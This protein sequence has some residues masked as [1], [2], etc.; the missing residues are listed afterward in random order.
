MRAT[1]YLDYETVVEIN[2]QHCGDGG[3]IRDEGG[4]R[5]TLGRA[6]ATFMGEDLHPTIVSKA[7]VILHGLSS[8]QYFLDGN[9]RTAWIVAKLFL[10]LNGHHLRDG[11][12]VEHETLVLS[13]ATKAFENEEHPERGAAKAAEWYATRRLT[14]Q[15]RYHYAFLSEH[16]ELVNSDTFV[17]MNG[18]L[19]SYFATELPA[20]AP[21]SLAIHI[22]W[23]RWDKFQDMEVRV[24]IEGD[25]SARIVA[26]TAELAAQLKLAESAGAPIDLTIMTDPKSTLNYSSISVVPIST[27]DP[28]HPD[29]MS[30]HLLI[31][32]LPVWLTDPGT[33]WFRV[34]VN[35]ELLTRLGLDVALDTGFFHQQ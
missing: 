15:D 32:N 13:V 4:I 12:D 34:E 35:G 23:L 28:R 8:T 6:E 24:S 30:P 11:S 27:E 20:F 2:A 17:A 16:A 33:A 5:A 31:Y 10:H 3:G 25:A 29:G 14:M 21:V 7:A 18:Q 9:K 22:R 19:G 1:R 26:P